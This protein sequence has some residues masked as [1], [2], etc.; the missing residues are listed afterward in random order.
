M[1]AMEFESYVMVRVVR[2]PGFEPLPEDEAGR[3][4]DA[5]LANIHAMHVA[6]QLIA[7]GPSPGGDENVR[8]WALM[9]TDLDTARELWANDPAVQAGV[10]VAELEPWI[11]PAR[12]IVPG[13]GVTPRSRAEANS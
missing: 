6:G 5:H 8:G 2:P 7:A 1:V 10:F 3:I 13:D 11:M 12:L 4:Q 9:T